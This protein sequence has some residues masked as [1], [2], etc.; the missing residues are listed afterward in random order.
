MCGA[1]QGRDDMNAAEVLD[2]VGRFSETGIKV[3]LDGG[4]G[5]DALLQEQTRPHTDLDV[6]IEERSVS[7]ARTILEARD[8]KDVPRDDSRPENFVLQDAQGNQVDFHVIRFDA[9]GNGVYGPAEAGEY[10]PAHAFEAVGHIEGHTV[11]CLTP[12][13][14]LESRKGYPLRP[15]DAADVTRLCEA[16]GLPLPNTSVDDSQRAQPHGLGRY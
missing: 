4:W 6:V 13:Y 2:I 3:W 5:V 10:Y 16:F 7:R 1:N 14:L 12:Q 9:C 11:V 15:K 8:Y